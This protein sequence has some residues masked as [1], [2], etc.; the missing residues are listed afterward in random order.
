MVEDTQ[1]DQG[2]TVDNAGA[3]IARDAV[4]A[5]RRQS[6]PKRI[7]KWVLGAIAV[8][9]LAVVGVVVGLNTPLGERYLAERL[10]REVFANGMNIRIGRIEGNIYGAAVLHDVAVS[11]PKGVFLTIPRAEVDWNPRGWLSYRLDVDSFAVRRAVLQRIPEFLP[12]TD[13]KPILPGF[14]I[15]VDRFEIDNLTLAPG[16]A[17]D[18]AQ[19]VDLLAAA[20]VED[21][22]LFVDAKGMLGRKDRLALLLNAEPD[23]DDFDLSLDYDAPADG[24]LAG[25]IGTNAAHTARIRGDG[26]WTVWNGGLLIRRNDERL[27]ALRITNRGGKFGLL[28]KVDPARM[29]DGAAARIVGNNVSVGAQVTIDNRVFD[30]RYAVIG[31]NLRVAADGVVDLA[32]NRVSGLAVTGTITNPAIFGGDLRLEKA[33]LDATIDGAFNDLAIVHDAR[34]GRMIIDT[35]ELVDLRQQGTA[36][37]DGTRWT[38]PLKL[39]VA[40]VKSGN[41]LI[42]PRLVNGTG[43]GTMT[44]TGTRLLSDDLRIVFPGTTANLALQGDVA[45]ESYRLR[46][47]VRAERLVLDNV[48]TAGGTAMID[49]AFVEGRPWTLSAQLDGRVAPV[50]N[51]TLANLAGPS[52]RVR[53]G[54]ALG[55]A[56]PITFR[57]LRLDAA[58]LRMALNGAVRDGRT[59][60][61][62]R[63]RHT[64]YGNF[65]VEAAIADD[66]PR[67]QLVFA[68][69]YNGLENVRVAI[70]PIKDGFAIETDGSSTLGPFT[71]KLGLFAPPKGPT[72]VDI[73]RLLVSE[74]LITGALMLEDGA[75]AGDLA[76]SGGGVNGTVALAPRDGGQG[77]NVALTARDARFGGATPLTIARADITAQGL[78]RDGNT[79]FTGEGTAQGV[80]YGAMFIGRMAARGEVTNGVGQVDARLVGR[81]GG[82][83]ALDLNAR[84]TREQIAL[85]MQG[86]HGGRKITMPRR[87]VLTSLEGGGWQLAPSQINYGSGGVIAEGQFGGDATQLGLKL[88]QMPLSPAD[89]AVS[90][91]GL[92]GTISGLVDY[93]LGPDGFPVGSAWV[94]IDD[95]TRSG[96]VVTSKPM[97]VGLIAKLTADTLEA[98]IVLQSADI[99]RGRI[100]AV[101]RDLPQSGALGERIRAG[102]LNAQLRFNGAAESLWRLAAIDAFDITGPATI[103]ADATGTLANPSVRGAVA[104]DALRVRSALSGTDI[105]DV[106]MR[107]RF[108]GSRLQL[109]QF[110]GTTGNGGRISGS[111]IVDLEGL[112]ERVEG[113]FLETRGPTLD[114][115]ASASKAKL[116]DA[117]GLSATIS[118][119]LRIVSNGLGGTIAGRVHID[120][121][122]WTL[123]NAAEDMRLPQISTREIKL[124]ADRAVEVTGTRPWRYLIDAKGNSRIDVD[125]MGLESEWGANIQLRGTTDDPRI[126]GKAEVVRGTYTFSGT[127]FDLTRGEIA[128][129]V[130]GPINPRLDIRAES[131]GSD[132]DVVVRVT[133]D[134]T[135]PEI[136]F[137]STP[138]L[139]EEEILARLLF[140]GSITTLSAT[141]ALQLGAAM[142]SLRGGAGMDPLNQLRSAI[143]LDRLRI[144]SADPAL[145]Q[146]TGVALGKNFGRRFYV[147]IITD[148]RGY[149]AT[150]VE[151]RVTSWLSLLGSIS[152]LG[153]ESVVAEI[154]RDY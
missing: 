89:F 144:V 97:D 19:R 111:G 103:S 72:R 21:R 105:R 66:G 39:A 43:A 3:D 108:A 135:Q 147:E 58:K 26:T 41:T 13:N 113:R 18:K 70:A 126:G 36:R 116:V 11:D 23:G 50:S 91:L 84:I 77:L 95:L 60:L 5:P 55:G 83:I 14:D 148:G 34:V 151:F 4:P 88:Y 90:D 129:D 25:I 9:L 73:E 17:G 118:G 153:R 63:G 53:G 140:G 86:E 87:A 136:A 71:G 75:V 46:G 30:G 74:T 137:T 65:T 67:A 81:R 12:S 122:S 20:K 101:I 119:P 152:T 124:P 79:N 1:P 54:F 92:G 132:L 45:A 120:R 69:P 99:S 143:G 146:G 59:T 112:G 24:A 42:D 85:A 56:G 125:G 57:D 96:T 82:R 131:E 16:I 104:S 7:A 40:R 76:L 28:G 127:Q 149:S 33:R 10:S 61:A 138:S 2:T 35:T 93:Q 32:N 107:G 109:T 115:R 133:G 78:I 51:A 106:S 29:L 123:G 37:Y 145:G 48:G 141:D 128:F 31:D 68:Q 102:N 142:A 100:Q 139:P 27:A 8:L 134:A 47:P 64:E 52:L 121:A 117:R 110:S 6:W 94:K 130:N 114:L 98:R 49:F 62:G 150:E 15:S 22:R 154:S 38:L 44:L 80:G